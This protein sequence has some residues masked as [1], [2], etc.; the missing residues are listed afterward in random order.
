[1]FC[2]YCGTRLPENAVFCP[3]CGSKVSSVKVAEKKI[4]SGSGMRANVCAACGSSDLKRIAKGEYLCGHCGTRF[5]TEEP[6]SVMSLEEKKA[7]LLVL[8]AEANRHAANGD[9]Q[10][11]LSTLSKGLELLP[12]DCT[13][14]LKLGRACSKLKLV[15]ETM[16]YYK[17]A[18]QVN[19]SDPVI[20][21]NQAVEYLKQ[22]MAKE[23]KPLMD[24]ALAMADADPMSMAAADLAV[25]Y[26]NY[27]LCIG[28]LGDIS[29]ARKYLKMAKQKGCNDDTVSYVCRTLNIRI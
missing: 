27:A 22:D 1:M 8:F 17:R 13:L 18:E 12:D 26:S 23:A 19:P 3:A 24:K 9:H 21:V 14:L 20:Y 16:D 2:I 25:T 5:F 28:K 10:A 29:G 11:E 6:D 4:P 7:K 15:Q